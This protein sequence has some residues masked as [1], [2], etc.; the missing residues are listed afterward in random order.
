[1]CRLQR[2]LASFQRPLVILCTLNSNGLLPY[3]TPRIL[4]LYCSS[5]TANLYLSFD[6]SIF[7]II[8][9]K[10][11]FSSRASVSKKDLKIMILRLY[12]IFSNMYTVQ[13]FKSVNY[14][15]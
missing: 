4:V 1:M 9:F 13:L 5:F 14:T 8:F 6:L 12:V 11:T 10:S 2:P 15:L 7:N 3:N